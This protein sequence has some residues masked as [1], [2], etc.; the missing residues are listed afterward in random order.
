MRWGPRLGPFVDLV[1]FDDSVAS[2]GAALFKAIETLSRGVF[3]FSTSAELKTKGAGGGGGGAGREVMDSN[4][5]LP[6]IFTFRHFL[7][8]SAICLERSDLA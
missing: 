2:C 5:S 7:A 1:E 4:K 6:W 8:V 3:F